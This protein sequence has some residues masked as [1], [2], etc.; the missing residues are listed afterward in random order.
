MTDA[1][2]RDLVRLL[3]PE[4]VSTDDAD[5][6][7]YAHDLWPRQLLATRGGFARP[8][9][10]QAIVW[11]TSTAQLSDL[12]AL[13]QTHGLGLLPFGAGS[14]VVG[15]TSAGRD[16]L[17]VDL[18]RLPRV[19][20][21]DRAAGTLRVDVGAL[22]QHL[23][24]WLQRQGVTLGHFPSSIYCS[25]VGGWVATR[26]AGQCSG[27]YGK[28]EDMVV[29]VE[30]VLGT[31]EVFRA[32]VPREGEVDAR[33]LLVGSEGT[34]GFLTEATLRV[35]PRP[36]S[37][38]GVAYTFHSLREAWTAMRGLYQS[39]LRPAVTRLY[40]PFDTYVFLQGHDKVAPVRPARAPVPKTPSTLAESVLRWALDRP[41]P[42]NALLDLATEHVYTRSLLIVG[43]EITAADDPEALIAAARRV[44]TEAGGRDEGDGPARRWL[45]RRHAVSYRQ[46]P[47]Y[48]QGLWVDTMEVAASWSCLDA[49]HTAVREALGHGGFVM[50][51]FSH[52][53]SDGCS[54][55]FT[56]AGASPTDAAALDT[57]DATWRR[58]LA[59]AH[60]AGGTVAHHHGV[61]RSKRGAMG[62]EWGAGVAVLEA[63]RR[64]A[65]PHDVLLRGA[66]V[67]DAGEAVGTRDTPPTAPVADALSRT[68]TAP[69][70]TDCT[71][72]EAT[73]RAA[74]MRFDP[75][76]APTLRHWL[77]ATRDL[78]TRQ[79]DPADHHVAGWQGRLPSGAPMGW[80]P[81]P[82]RS[83]GPD[84]LPLL[85]HDPRFGALD[86]VTLRLY[87]TTESAPAYV[88]PVTAPP[89]G[90]SP[91]VDAWIDRAA[92]ALLAAG[93]ERQPG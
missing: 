43:F 82:R 7:A 53:Y 93:H 40:D 54:I 84:V 57:Y 66:L 65:D 2:T 4:A 51:H 18:K 5:R 39:G 20:T 13:A 72:L 32:G 38:Q 47:T 89:T 64:G 25:T 3:G 86:T 10:P 74:G 73:A 85:V 24:S 28:I 37:F 6:S 59:A 23:E 81:C 76:G 31:G 55:Y 45:S 62:L 48:A 27:R 61:G 87:G 33:A 29:G 36:T 83:A 26:G 50:A 68:V 34:F 90:H 15:A 67:P 78:S 60:A 71:A 16:T 49:L 17:S 63:L 9:G 69:I 41:K 44:C 11:P 21:L 8:E 91:S 1:L 58:A 30:G 52:A 14:G 80:L 46:P 42:L 56:F 75:H 35:W 88:A 22:G 92:E 77:R 19:R 70:D 12:V 79:D